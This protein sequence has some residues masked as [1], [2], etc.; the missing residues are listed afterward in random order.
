[1]FF[2][3]SGVYDITSERGFYQVVSARFYAIPQAEIADRAF[4]QTQLL[5]DF[6]IAFSAVPQSR[7][8]LLDGWR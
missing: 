7:D 1:L 8:P 5:G 2:K 4:P 6:R 3:A